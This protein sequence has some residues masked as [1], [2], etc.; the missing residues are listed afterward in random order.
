[1]HYPIHIRFSGLES[2]PA[3]TEAAQTHAHGLP[4]AESEIL[5]CWVGIHF[6]PNELPAGLPYSARVDVTI[7]GYELISQRVPH[8]DV[9]LALGHAFEDMQHQLRR[10]DPKINH[11]EFAV[12]INGQLAKPPASDK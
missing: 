8:S 4:W 6:H 9:H 5:N 10:I 3:L 11:A 7:P 12:T 2:C 1:M